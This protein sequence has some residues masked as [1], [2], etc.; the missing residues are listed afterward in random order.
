MSRANSSIARILSLLFL[1]KFSTIS[2][3]IIVKRLKIIA[4]SS[5]AAFAE[6]RVYV[7][8]L[9]GADSALMKCMLRLE[10]LKIPN[11][12]QNISTLERNERNTALRL[13]GSDPRSKILWV[14][15]AS[16]G[17]CGKPAKH[18]SVRRPRLQRVHVDSDSLRCAND[19]MALSVTSLSS[20]DMG[21]FSSMPSKKCRHGRELHNFSISPSKPVNGKPTS[22]GA[23]SQS[24]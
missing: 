16:Y 6:A 8:V 3:P 18:S 20:M 12:G 5:L 17:L 21:P 2:S 14:S 11:V 15:C 22:E 13:E 24:Q 4:V 9:G 1:Y 10:P 23:C 7:S 19:A